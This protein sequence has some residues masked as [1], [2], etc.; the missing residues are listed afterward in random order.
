MVPARF[1]NKLWLRGQGLWSPKLC[2]PAANSLVWVAPDATGSAYRMPTR[3][4]VAQ[5]CVTR[6]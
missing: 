6:S 1:A 4:L 2:S 5:A 3:N